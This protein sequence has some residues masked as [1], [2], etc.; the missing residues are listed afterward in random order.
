MRVLVTGGAGFLGRHVARVVQQAGHHVTVFD[1]AASNAGTDSICGD[2]TNPADCLRATREADAICHLGGIGDVYLAMEDP[3]LAAKV[4]VYG[5][6]NLLE[7]ARQNG[8]AKLVYASTWEVYGHPH[9]QPID[10]CH[11]CAPDHPYNVTKFA[12]ELLTLS[13][14]RLKGLPTLA[15]RLGTAYGEGMRPNS[16]FSLFIARARQGQPIVIQGDGSQFRQFTHAS[17]I[18]RGFTLGLESDVHGVALN[19][20]SPERT[21]IRDL[22]TLNT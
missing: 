1:L 6:A 7:A 8:V 13:Y 9:Y 20:V 10:E 3:A 15:L 14:D 19:I 4:N 22:A 16:V 5:T 12:G 17:D 11:P 2:L 18:G 21:S